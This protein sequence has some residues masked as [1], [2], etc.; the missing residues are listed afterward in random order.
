MRQMPLFPPPV[1]PVTGKRCKNH[2][3]QKYVVV[4]IIGEIALLRRW[5]SSPSSGSFAPLDD[6]IDAEHE[7]VTVG[8]REMLAKLNNGHRGFAEVASN[9]L[10]TAQIRVSGEQVRLLIEADGRRVLRQQKDGTLTPVFQ[11]SDCKI[12]ADAVADPTAPPRT[13][14]GAL[15]AKPVTRIYVGTDGVM[16]PVIKEDEKVLRRKK[17]LQKR[18]KSGKKC[19]PLRPRKAGWTGNY[20]EFKVVEFHD[21][22]G[23]FTHQILTADKRTATGI[24]I[25]RHALRLNFAQA[26]ERIC[27]VDGANWI[28]TQLEANATS[29]KLDGVG[30]D[31]WHFAEH[32]HSCRRAVYG[33]ESPAGKT[34]AETLAECFMVKGFEAGWES[35]IAW[36]MTLKRG[37]KRQA[38]DELMNYT[39]VRREMINYPQFRQYGWQIGSGPT[40][41]RCKTTTYRLKA[42]GCRWDIRNA[43]AVAA[44]TTLFDSGQWEKYWQLRT[45][46]VT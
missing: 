6:L 16:V 43:E 26:D 13:L 14:A 35:L 15:G 37:K 38:A 33:P 23:K 4:S 36:R 5:W 32:I 20:R 40:E 30:L 25:R 11:A 22:T 1:D 7:T 27:N 41:A 39:S 24:H 10:R 29:L 46:L 21:E 17:V 12:P 19:R 34:W 3:Q 44:L 2:G 8:V 45:T 31:Y 28:P 42:P 9:L 18:Q